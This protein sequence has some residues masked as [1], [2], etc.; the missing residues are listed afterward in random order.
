MA[1]WEYCILSGM[2]T[3]MKRRISRSL[4]FSSS[5]QENQ[6]LELE[7][8]RDRSEEMFTMR[9]L[10][11]LGSNGWELVAFHRASPKFEAVLKRPVD[12]REAPMPVA[13]SI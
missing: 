13:A 11:E 8:D 5:A 6:S 3:S 7:L 2:E 1:N 9:Y 10:G 12:L 4:I